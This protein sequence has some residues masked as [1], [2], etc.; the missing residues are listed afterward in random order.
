MKCQKV[1]T[2]QA[3]PSGLLQ[4]LTIPSQLWLH[5]TMDFVEGLPKSQGFDSM[6]VVVDR[7][8][9][10]GHFTPITHPFSTKY[11]A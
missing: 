7:L 10:Y 8:T 4:P 9:K 11:V 3:K 2:D 6:W 1:K 5:I